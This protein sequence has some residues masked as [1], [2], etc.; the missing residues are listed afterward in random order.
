MVNFQSYGKLRYFEECH[1]DKELHVIAEFKAYLADLNE[2][3]T[4]AIIEAERI[5]EDNIRYYE[6]S[7]R[8]FDKSGKEGRMN[9]RS[10]YIMRL[11][12]Y[13]DTIISLYN[14]KFKK[15]TINVYNTTYTY[16]KAKIKDE[17]TYEI[18]P[19]V[20]VNGKDI[21]FTINRENIVE[22]VDNE[23]TIKYRNI[24]EDGVIVERI[25][26]TDYGIVTD[27]GNT[28]IVSAFNKKLNKYESMRFKKFVTPESDVFKCV[29]ALCKLP[30]EY[31][32]NNKLEDTLYSEYDIYGMEKGYKNTMVGHDMFAYMVNAEHVEDYASSSIHPVLLD[33]SNLNVS[34]LD[35]LYAVDYCYD[36][37]GEDDE[38]Y[39]IF[40]REV[41]EVSSEEVDDIMKEIEKCKI[42]KKET[43]NP[44][45]FEEILEVVFGD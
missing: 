2:D 30:T 18:T 24:R 27:M 37:E 29:P 7:V 15:Q 35:S 28:I 10:S 19:F 12:T 22:R 9:F 42:E 13:R 25:I 43:C 4:G 33:L 26:L 1:I 41:R 36:G 17:Y 3:I 11:D 14:V 20:D 23:L 45:T 34:F 31:Y 44:Y 6:V 40:T 38:R 32:R 16:E 8:F 5:V 21:K 39:S